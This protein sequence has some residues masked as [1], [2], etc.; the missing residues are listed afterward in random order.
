[1]E[2]NDPRALPV[3]APD[4]MDAVERLRAFQQMGVRAI[5]NFKYVQV[6]SYHY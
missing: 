1:M 2:A 3:D 5:P 4:G 6:D